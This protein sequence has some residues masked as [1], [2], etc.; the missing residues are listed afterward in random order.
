M[1]NIYE[2]LTPVIDG[3]PDRG[4]TNDGESDADPFLSALSEHAERNARRVHPIPFPHVTPT[5]RPGQKSQNYTIWSVGQDIPVEWMTEDLSVS[6]EGRSVPTQTSGADAGHYSVQHPWDVYS[7]STNE[8]TSSKTDGDSSS[9]TASQDGTPPHKR[10]RPSSLPP[11]QSELLAR[12]YLEKMGKLLPNLPS[13]ASVVGLVKTAVA[14]DFDRPMTRLE[15]EDMEG[16]SGEELSAAEDV[17]RHRG[18]RVLIPVHLSLVL[19]SH[20][21]SQSVG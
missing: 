2:N 8:V 9:S 6:R 18:P 21:A 3:R 10:G 12:W 16:L 14:S 7:E 4:K 20:L 11:G 17:L 1:E 5:P 13:E 15:P 19:P